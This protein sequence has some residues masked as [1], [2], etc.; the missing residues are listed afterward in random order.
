MMSIGFLLGSLDDAV[1][2]RG[3]KK[4]GK[5]RQKLKLV[6][7][8]C[9]ATHKTLNISVLFSGRFTEFRYVEIILQQHVS[10]MIIE[11]KQVRLLVFLSELNQTRIKKNTI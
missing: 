2:W 1:I 8:F 11:L 5:Y 9:N 10:C 6:L 4:N 7:S 3:P